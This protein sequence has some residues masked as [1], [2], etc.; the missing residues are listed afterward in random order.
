MPARGVKVVRSSS[1]N[2]SV[3]SRRRQLVAQPEEHHEGDDIRRILSPVEKASCPLVE[4]A[5]T[6]IAAKPPVTL[7]RS[8][9]TFRD[10]AVATRDTA[11]ELDLL[12]MATMP[13]SSA[14]ANERLAPPLTE[15]DG[16][17]INRIDE[18]M[19]WE[20]AQ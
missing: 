13:L 7:S 18:L 4:V 11:H 20:P 3:R 8:F 17:P 2:T 16:H 19:P 10:T 6:I 9:G 14:Q 15:P 12:L 1:T 5:P